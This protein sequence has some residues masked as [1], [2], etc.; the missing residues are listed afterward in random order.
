VAEQIGHRRAAMIAHHGIAF[1]SFEL[2]DLTLARE[3]CDAGLAIAEALGARR[4]IS[5][6]LML[7][8]QCEFLA[9]DS[10]SVT[11]LKAGID[12]ARETPNYILPL[13]L[14]L[15]ATFTRSEA[16]GKAALAEGE[17]LLA[18]GAVSH[19]YLFFS[20][21]AM[22]ACIAARDWAGARHYAALM[23]RS[24]AAEP[25]PMSDF[26]VAR[27]R[28][29]AAAG[30]GHKDAAQ[31]RALIDQARAAKWQAVIPA[32]EAALAA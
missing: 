26:L 15:L 31:L 27:A 11:T 8:A 30:E 7:R 6:G 29:I 16:E 10:S 25:F 9:G 18:T 1:L 14:S 28:A 23:E 21:H 13:G 32:L 22:D 3:A 17:A 19:N 2:H 12:I 24:M 20:R 5:E 4:F